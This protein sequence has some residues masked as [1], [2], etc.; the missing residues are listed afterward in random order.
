MSRLVSPLLSISLVCACTAEAPASQPAAEQPTAKQPT[1]PPTT[2]PPAAEP[3]S[4]S[5]ARP[6]APA[7]DPQ[8][9]SG[10]HI[11]ITAEQAAAAGLPALGFS[12][13][14]TGMGMSGSQLGNGEYL[15]LSGPPG[16]PLTLRIA[17]STIDAAFAEIEGAKLVEEQV[18]LLGEPRRAA[19]WITGES[20]AR[21]SWCAVI[22][23]PPGAKSGDPALL[24]EVGVGHQGDAL[25]C[26]TALDGPKLGSVVRSLK[27]E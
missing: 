19:A 24:L 11:H 21:T 15:H 4:P 26:A 18:E 3:T 5:Q 9:V 20:L 13:E 17:P 25:A 23:G 14:T 27:L 12:L 6:D 2:E 1:E 10:E 8:P 22:I 16:G 7:K